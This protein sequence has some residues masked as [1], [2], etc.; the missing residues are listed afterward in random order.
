MIFTGNIRPHHILL[1][2][3]S[4]EA[5]IQENRTEMEM[6]LWDFILGDSFPA[7]SVR[8]ENSTWILNKPNARWIC[9]LWDVVA[10]VGGMGLLLHVWKGVP[11]AAFHLCIPGAW[12][13]HYSQHTSTASLGSFMFFSKIDY[14]LLFQRTQYMG[15][16]KVVWRE[17]VDI[18]FSIT[19]RWTT[20]NLNPPKC[21][22]HNILS[23][24][25][26]VDM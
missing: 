19:F 16:R 6:D 22:S 3:S 1:R 23:L 8:D 12:E 2:S 5:V 10:A 11:C 24:P 21:D 15:K 25:F 26:S 17:E 9:S 14:F 13:G 18:T 20:L 4:M 7:W